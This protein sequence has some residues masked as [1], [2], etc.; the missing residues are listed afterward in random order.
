M[1][2]KDE[3]GREGEGVVHSF[4]EGGT[5]SLLDAGETACEL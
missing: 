2:G 1:P 4:L 5:C 3:A